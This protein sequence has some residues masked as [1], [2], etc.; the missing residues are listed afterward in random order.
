MGNYLSKLT[1]LMIAVMGSPF[2]SLPA[3]AQT[4][5]FNYW[6]N[7][8]TG[9]QE[10]LRN[11]RGRSRKREIR[12]DNQEKII[13][14][15]IDTGVEYRTIP[16]RFEDDRFEDGVNHYGRKKRRFTPYRNDV[17]KDFHDHQI[18][19]LGYHDYD[20]VQPRIEINLDGY[21]LVPRIERRR[22]YRKYNHLFYPNSYP[23]K[24]SLD[25]RFNDGNYRKH[26]F[27]RK[28]NFY[29]Y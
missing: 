10:C 29:H 24:P 19:P 5:C 2:Y 28:H 11:I 17:R 9:K 14:P 23:R 27:K 21:Y 6:V 16:N 20:L 3:N 13:N 1:F 12:N 18:W 8:T 4:R 15:T 26:R 25:S 22:R 7:P